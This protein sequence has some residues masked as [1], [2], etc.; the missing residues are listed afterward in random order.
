MNS[1]LLVGDDGAMTVF[2]H[3][4]ALVSRQPLEPG[5]ESGAGD[6]QPAERCEPAA[7]S[8]AADRARYELSL[9]TASKVSGQGRGALRFP[10]ATSPGWTSTRLP[11]AGSRA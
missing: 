10:A 11:M 7:H 4:R 3:R 2:Q 6:L 9:I 5:I 1:Q 8:R